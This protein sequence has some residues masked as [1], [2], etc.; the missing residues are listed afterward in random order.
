MRLQLRP[1]MV[2]KNRPIKIETKL[3]LNCKLEHMS[4][5]DSQTSS[6]TY[7][8]TRVIRGDFGHHF[9]MVKYC[10]FPQKLPQKLSQGI[11]NDRKIRNRYWTLIYVTLFYPFSSKII[12]LSHLEIPLGRSFES[13][14][15]S[16]KTGEVAISSVTFLQLQCSLK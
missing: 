15:R 3:Q 9:L 5:S 12:I 11:S 13:W 16:E 1:I 4:E 10:N 7:Q 2:E 6:I 8:K 14:E